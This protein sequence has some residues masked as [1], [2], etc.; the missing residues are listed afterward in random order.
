MSDTPGSKLPDD[1]ELDELTAYLV[2]SSRLSS[3]E[4]RRLIDEVIHFLDELPEDF[5][6]RRHYA[7]QAQGLSNADIFTRLALELRI[8]RFRAPEYTERQLRR[9]IYG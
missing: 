3:S 7:L 2:A 8:R 5:V 1:T 4:A 9:I 6:R